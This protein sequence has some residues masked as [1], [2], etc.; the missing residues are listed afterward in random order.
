M[1]L[2]CNKL[3]LYEA[4][5]NV[6]KA[7]A[8][9]STIPALEGIKINLSDSTLNLTGYD[10]EIGIKTKISVRSQDSGEFIVNARLFNEIIKRMPTEEIMIEVADNLAITITG[11]STQYTISATTAEEYP[12]IPEFN[13]GD[14]FSISQSLLKNMINQTIFAVATNDTKPILTG[15]LFDIEDGN[16]NL[17]A[18]DGYRLAIRTEKI[19]CD[20]NFKFVVPA[21]ALNEVSK[22]LKDDDELECVI[23]TCKKHIIFDISGY[24]VI[25]RLLEGEFH[26]YKGSIPSS[27]NTEVVANTKELISCLERASLLINERIKSPVRCLFDNGMVKMTCSTSIGKINDEINV[28]ITGPLIEIGFNNKYFLDPLKTI[29][30]DKVKLLMNGSNLPMKITPLSGDSYTFLVLPVRLKNE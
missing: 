19:N 14:F 2:F 25:S 15:E 17:V 4:I 23:H 28:D 20:K 7:V 26:N 27:S 29:E 13:E 24:L 11:G 8:V 18:I 10:L 12:E 1:K 16:F 9:K 30:D 5:N 6:S 21:K 22:L 3:S